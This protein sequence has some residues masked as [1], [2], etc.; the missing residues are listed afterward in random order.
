MKNIISSP[1]FRI[2]GILAILYYGLFYDKSEADS[3]G[4]RFSAHQVKKNFRDAASKSLYMI[5]NVKKAEEIS[6]TLVQQETSKKT[7]GK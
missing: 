1:I 2:V 6:K 5:E 4:N 7:D 3:L